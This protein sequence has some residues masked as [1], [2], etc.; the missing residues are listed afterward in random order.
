MDNF[1][2]SL[3]SKNNIKATYESYKP[4]LSEIM[5]KIED[6]LR[7][8]VKLASNPTYKS[9]VKSFNSYYRKV[10]RLK[11][12]EAESSN[13][14]ELTDMMGI[15]VICAFL[16]DLSEVEQQIKD[17][18]VVKEVEYKGAQQSFR[19]FGYESVHVLVSIPK[20]CMPKTIL[21]QS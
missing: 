16:E 21:A 19:E 6:K 13:F 7:K 15:R 18:F 17:N 5:S 4:I 12:D 1:V 3:P 14:V 10:L 9:R 8:T 2:N 20:D 11:S